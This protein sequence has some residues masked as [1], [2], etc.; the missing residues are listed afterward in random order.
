MESF[1]R[2]EDGREPLRSA[3]HDL[4][5]SLFALRTGIQLLSQ[6]RD[7]AAQFNE[8]RDLLDREVQTATD[9]LKDLLDLVTQ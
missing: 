7:D 1:P 2:E 5:H 3:A 8:L 6:V 4:R 9:R